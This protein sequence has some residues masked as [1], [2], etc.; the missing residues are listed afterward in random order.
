MTRIQ[1]M[2]SLLGRHAVA[3]IY[4]SHSSFFALASNV[5]DCARVPCCGDPGP[6][7]NG[8][9]YQGGSTFIDMGSTFT[10]SS[11]WRSTNLAKL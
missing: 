11:L 4:C 2:M 3:S 5:V 7:L 1:L 8:P 6:Y 9:V 10:F